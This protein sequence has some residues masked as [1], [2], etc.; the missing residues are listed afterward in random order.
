MDILFLTSDSCRLQLHPNQDAKKQHVAP[1]GPVF[2]PH[3]DYWS[4]QSQRLS[5]QKVTKTCTHILP[6]SAVTPTVQH[7]HVLHHL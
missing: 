5:P 7:Q 4:G 6:K 1:L 3:E 2:G